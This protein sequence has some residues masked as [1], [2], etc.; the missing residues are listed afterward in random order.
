LT[1]LPSPLTP[2][3]CD[4]RDFAF[5]PLDVA[6]LRRSKAWLKAK[7]NPALAFY[8]INLWTASWHDMP[9][10][11]LENDDDVLADLAMCEPGKWTKIRADVLYGW[12]ECSDGRLY[13]PTV[14]EKAIDA[15]KAKQAQ[16]QRTEAAR[17][18]KEQKR[19]ATQQT[20]SQTLKA[21]SVT[22]SVTEAAT[23]S[24]G[25]G[26]REGQGQGDSISVPDGT[27]ADGA[28]SPADMTKAELWSVGKSILAEQG[29]P[30][31]QCGSFVGKLCKDF[32]DD[33]VIEAVRATCVTRPADAAEYLKATCM[34]AA[35]KRTP[36]NRQEAIEQRNRE[37]A[38]RWADQGETHVAH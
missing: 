25:E 14:A 17:L 31:A 20:L 12:I 24:K 2:A 34:H 13:H 26:Q 36:I 7:R 28:T 16:R 38:D 15:W 3:D 9:A 4:L 11:S 5:M 6:R 10:A 8:M 23:A 18:A 29:M 1:D 21:A 33:I 22:G 37:A 19:I 35:G 30:K 27:G 32:G